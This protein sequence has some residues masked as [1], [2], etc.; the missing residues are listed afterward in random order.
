MKTQTLENRAK[1]A[2][3]RKNT[4]AYRVIYFLLNNPAQQVFPNVSNKHTA[5]EY[6]ADVEYWAKK[7]NIDIKIG[8]DW[9]K[10]PKGG[11]IGKYAYLA[12]KKQA[13]N[14]EER[15]SMRYF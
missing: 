8:H 9:D 12:N 5:Q 15:V 6:T 10:A 13:I 1:K 11:L 3:L 7:F 4:V 2:G 14:K